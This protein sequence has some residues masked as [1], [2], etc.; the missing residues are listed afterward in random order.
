MMRIAVCLALLVCTDALAL[1][2]VAEQKVTPMQKVIA[3]LTGLRTE[4]QNDGKKEAAT[5]TKFARFCKD[6]TKKVSDSIKDGETKIRGLASDHGVQSS[7][8][9]T[10]LADNAKRNTK[11][12]ALATSLAADNAACK[13]DK[14][15]Y[16]ASAADQNGAVASLKS[17][18]KALSA[19]KPTSMIQIRSI[20]S[21]ESVEE[22]VMQ[23]ASVD[24]ASASFAYHSNDIVSLCESLL[25]S[26]KE[27]KAAL[28]SD[29]KKRSD[30]CT[31]LKAST[32]GQI[33]AN[34]NAM[35][36]NTK[37]IF[38]FNQK[39]AKDKK[40]L[41]E[42]KSKLGDDALV[43]KD[44][45][46]S[47]ESRAKDWDQRT[48]GRAGEI[49]ALTAAL[50]ALTGG[51]AAADSA[52]NKR[53]ALVNIRVHKDVVDVVDDVHD[54]S[55]SDTDA[56]DGSSDEAVKAALESVQEDED[57]SA[58]AV[59]KDASDDDSDADDALKAVEKEDEEP[60]AETSDDEAASLLQTI[61]KRGL[62]PDRRIH[63]SL[64]A[65]QVQAR[66]IGSLSLSALTVNARGSPF[67]KIKGLMQ[68]LMEWLLQESE[69]EATKKGF[70]DQKLGTLKNTQ[71]DQ[72]EEVSDISTKINGLETDKDELTAEIAKLSKQLLANEDALAKSSKARA[73][74]KTENTQA[75][76]TARKGLAATK[77]ATKVLRNYY[78]EAAKA[79][80][81]LQASPID[82]MKDSNAGFKGS[83]KGAQGS[84]DAIVGFLET[85]QSDFDR[86]ISKTEASEDTAQ[87]AYV[88]LSTGMKADASGKTTAKRLDQQDL[89]ET[90]TDL[91]DAY[92][93]LSAN[94]GLLD[95]AFKNNQN[96]V[97]T[98][99]DTGMS[100][101]DRVAK[102]AAEIQALEQALKDLAPK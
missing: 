76:T 21:K 62:S 45:T 46:A 90:G 29:W 65:L 59:T 7:K 100:Y 96:L 18:I 40:D 11:K 1:A 12:E 99:V 85:I 97:S 78:S 82:G 54:D 15:T 38:E 47:C 101:S 60:A 25:K 37:Q 16:E 9:A 91:E 31:S 2:N 6:E 75:V 50:S 68:K 22:M 48:T 86:T 36:V 63:R 3:L 42:S 43:L 24:P 79:A 57:A 30:S 72:W 55:S 73:D 98:C 69:A 8:K 32:E 80:A 53:A 89:K 71:D 61:I 77:V 51:A 26:S 39:L 67:K 87:R 58:D 27:K 20:L 66:K 23:K 92:G 28:D 49:T 13:S 5:Y 56:S 64:A 84:M 52:V 44:L 95:N 102:R 17:A 34:A 33:D 94:M 93:K 81:L 14:S 88:E 83:Y 35:K 41:T 74:D 10:E 19:A 4:V 70:C